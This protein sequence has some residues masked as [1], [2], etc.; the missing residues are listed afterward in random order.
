[1]KSKYSVKDAIK[2]QEECKEKKDAPYYSVTEAI[3]AQEEYCKRN[4]VPFF[5][6]QS[7]RCFSCGYNIFSEPYGYTVEYA[8]KKLVTGCPHCMTSFVD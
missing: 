1:M 8:K 7:G 6:P 3:K 5:A 2:S 4:N